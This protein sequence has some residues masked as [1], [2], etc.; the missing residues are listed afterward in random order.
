ML[1]CLL[2]RERERER[3]TAVTVKRLIMLVDLLVSYKM[4]NRRRRRHKIYI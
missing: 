3:V 2:E 4:F 1:A